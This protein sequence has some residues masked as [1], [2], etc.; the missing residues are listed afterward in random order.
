MRVW[1]ITEL[2]YFTRFELCQLHRRIEN[3][4]PRFPT[5]SIE[6]ATALESL[7]NIRI[8]RTRRDFLP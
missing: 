8:V 6:F 3:K 5:G 7:R 2:M 1:T 4:L